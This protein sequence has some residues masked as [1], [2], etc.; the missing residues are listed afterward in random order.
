MKTNFARKH[1]SVPEILVDKGLAKVGDVFVNFV[2]SLAVSNKRGI[3]TNIRVSSTI[4]SQALKKTGHRKYL[5]SRMD[6]HEQG[7]AVEALI[8]YSWLEGNLSLEECVSI[9]QREAD[10]PVDAFATLIT[11]VI[12]RLDL[13]DDS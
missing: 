2:F 6:R 4:L 3:P 5:P 13:N 7:D 1:V 8:F 12:E 9:L 10:M 11:T